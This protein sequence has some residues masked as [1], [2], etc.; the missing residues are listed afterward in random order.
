MIERRS[1]PADWRWEAVVGG[2][3]LLIGAGVGLS[4]VLSTGS[5]SYDE[6]MYASKALAYFDALNG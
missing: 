1:I 3:L 6:A 2:G 4:H 5:L